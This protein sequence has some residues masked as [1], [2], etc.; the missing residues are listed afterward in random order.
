MGLYIIEV[1]KS[2]T[3]YNRGSQ[4]WDFHNLYSGCSCQYRDLIKNGTLLY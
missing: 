2:G 4:K 1:V 3:L